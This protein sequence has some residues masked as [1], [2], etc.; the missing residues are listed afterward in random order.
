M[1]KTGAFKKICSILLSVLL[2]ISVFC[3]TVQA[4]QPETGTLQS[5][6]LTVYASPAEYSNVTAY[7][8]DFDLEAMTA[9][10]R[11]YVMNYTLLVKLSGS[12]SLR[13]EAT[14]ENI[15][16]L[17]SLI[18]NEIPEAFHFEHIQAS[19]YTSNNQIFQLTFTYNCQPDEYAY[20]MYEIEREA[21]TL[22][23]GIV[24]N[25]QLTDVQK[26]LLLH[27]RLALHC[28]YGDVNGSYLDTATIYGA[29]VGRKPVCQGYAIAYMYLLEKV[30]IESDMCSSDRLNHA[31]NIVYI[32]NEAYHV[33]VTW[34]DPTPDV[35]GQVY[36][37]NF[38]LSTQALKKGISDD[39]DTA[40]NANDFD[41]T[42]NSTKYDNAFWQHSYTA[43]Q[44]LDDEIYYIDNDAQALCRE[45][46]KA[47][48]A[49]VSDTWFTS[50]DGYYMVGNY[51][52]LAADLQ[53]LYYNLSDS[54]YSFDPATKSSQLIYT[55]PMTHEGET[56]YSI[57]GF[58]Y[59]YGI[60]QLDLINRTHIYRTTNDHCSHAEY[61]DKILIEGD[62]ANEGGTRHICTLCLAFYDT[63]EKNPARHTGNKEYSQKIYPTCGE[64]GKQRDTYCR[65]CGEL[66]EEGAVIPATGNHT[67]DEGVPEDSDICTGVLVYTYT[68]TVCS[69]TKQ[70]TKETDSPVHT[71]ETELRNEKNAGC[72][73]SGYTGDLC[74][75][76]CDHVITPGQ[77]I[78]PTEEHTW[79]EGYVALAPTVYDTGIY[80]YTCTVC[81]RSKNEVMPKLTSSIKGDAST[82]GV[83]NAADAR[84][85]LRVS[86]GLEQLD[87]DAFAAADVD[88]NGSITSADA[89]LILRYSVGLETE[90]PQ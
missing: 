38:L 24:D 4:L 77:V 66:L 17:A 52:C 9:E 83:I 11:Q 79:D 34:D 37:Y 41:T 42:P 65:D 27:D 81:N 82:D 67:W 14:Q 25:D 30:G 44:L 43:F 86:V 78:P 71:G 39:Y 19:Y 7:A 57:A 35:A 13:I 23:Y 72:G 56:Y 29:L 18:V 46:D 6:P 58:A 12:S 16:L 33:D 5:E 54:I 74:C 48:L 70:E 10:L 60:M 8:D 21:D 63:I 88:N 69:A 1:I 2:L 40:H 22:L 75:T 89:R 85:A 53:T 73:T 32:D 50:A 36:H 47:V 76:A 3:T 31:W 15:N 90:W 84:I 61:T 49:D 28:E 68:C 62:C 45:S 26:A 59:Q 80:R 55:P 20:K 87:G 51:T 64:D